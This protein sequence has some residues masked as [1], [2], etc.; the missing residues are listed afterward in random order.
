MDSDTIFIESE[1]ELLTKLLLI[2]LVKCLSITL[3]AN[4]ITFVENLYDPVGFLVLIFF[5]NMVYFPDSSKLSFFF[6]NVNA[7]SNNRNASMVFIFLN[8]FID[9]VLF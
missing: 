6:F 3:A 7:V 4:L 8:Y 5:S 9:S 1:N 2:L